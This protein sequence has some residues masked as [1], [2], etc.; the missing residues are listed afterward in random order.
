MVEQKEAKPK[1]RLVCLEMEGKMVPRHGY[2]IVENG[3]KTGTVTSGTFSPSL[4]KPIALAYVPA[5]KSKVG[6]TVEIAIRDKQ[7][8]AQ[9]VKPPFYKNASHK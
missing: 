3:K 2:D 7:V 4:Q 9:V 1:R 6:S 5:E 8:T